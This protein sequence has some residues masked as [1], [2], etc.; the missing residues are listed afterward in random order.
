MVVVLCFGDGDSATIGLMVM[1]GFVCAT[2]VVASTGGRA[3]VSYVYPC[4]SVA[5]HVMFVCREVRTFVAHAVISWLTGSALHESK[6]SSRSHHLQ[7]L[8]AQFQALYASLVTEDASSV[9]LPL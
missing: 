3:Y 7:V 4:P 1:C 9:A 2:G 8:W 5:V 6:F